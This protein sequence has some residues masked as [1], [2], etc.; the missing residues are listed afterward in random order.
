MLG[1]WVK[2]KT[3]KHP[4]FPSH[5]PDEKLFWVSK[6]PLKMQIW[7][8]CSLCRRFSIIRYFSQIVISFSFRS[9]TDNIREG[10][11]GLCACDEVDP[12]QD[13]AQWSMLEGSI[14]CWGCQLEMN[15]E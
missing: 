7:P 9:P 3:K 12:S 11:W 10:T 5:S 13:G 8:V 14:G 6:P 4:A 15:G 1:V 2:A